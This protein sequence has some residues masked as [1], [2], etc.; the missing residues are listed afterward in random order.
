MKKIAVHTAAGPNAAL[1][2]ERAALDVPDVEFRL[3]GRCS[4]PEAVA[5][6]ADQENEALVEQLANFVGR[7]EGSPF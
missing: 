5:E 6:A 3:A 7:A 2:G 1:P 4:T